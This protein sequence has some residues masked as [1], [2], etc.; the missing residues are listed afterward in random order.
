MQRRASLPANHR[1]TLTSVSSLSVLHQLRGDPATAEKLAREAY[2]GRRAT[3]PKNDRDTLTSAN[4]L[5]LLLRQRGDTTAAEPA[6]DRAPTAPEDTIAPDESLAPAESIA[7]DPIDLFE[8]SEAFSVGPLGAMAALGIPR[9]KVNPWGGGVSLRG[10]GANVRGR[11][12]V[13]P[14]AVGPQNPRPP[15]RRCRPGRHA[16]LPAPSPRRSRGRCRRRRR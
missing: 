16:R 12:G 3:L 13:R 9:E 4:N 1:D 15:C 8:I 5:A 2:D 14:R 10:T 7:I 11:P 6:G